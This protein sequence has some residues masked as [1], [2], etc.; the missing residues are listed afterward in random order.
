MSVGVPPLAPLPEAQRAAF[1]RDGFRRF[2]HARRARTCGGSIRPATPPYGP[3]A[4]FLM[5]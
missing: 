2:S 3:L 5:R 1:L 4:R